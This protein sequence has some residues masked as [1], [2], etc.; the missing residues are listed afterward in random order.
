[1]PLVDNKLPVRF[2]KLV[3]PRYLTHFQAERFAKLNAV[4][5]I[6]HRFAPAIANMNVNGAMFV[7][8]KEKPPNYLRIPNPRGRTL[9]APLG[10]HG[11][12][13]V[14]SSWPSRTWARR[15][16]SKL[17]FASRFVSS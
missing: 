1:M 7:A 8:V 2:S 3:R 17:S 11:E 15:L 14:Q 12:V 10:V 6:E 5:D 13:L 9:R 16:S 4:F